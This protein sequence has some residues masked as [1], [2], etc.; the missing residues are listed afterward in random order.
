MPRR[1]TKDYVQIG[2]NTLAQG[3]TRWDFAEKL[4][5]TVPYNG[6]FAK[7]IAARPARGAELAGFAVMGLRVVSSVVEE[8]EGGTGSLTVTLE[9][10][11]PEAE[12]VTTEAIGE[13]V[14]TVEWVELEKKIETLPQCGYVSAAGAA[15]GITDLAD[16]WEKILANPDYYTDRGTTGSWTHTDYTDLKKRGVESKVVYYPKV[17]R[18]T[19]HFA[20]P[21][22]LGTY[23]GERQ[24]PP[25]PSGFARLSDFEW[26]CGPDS[27]TRTNKMYERRTEW[28]GAEEIDAILYPE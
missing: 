25:I 19:V 7:C 3:M 28:I 12:D 22:D 13:P 9:A 24:T 16:D 15:A 26:L 8:M 2:E 20:K 18:T 5:V 27:A 21:A 6:P 4:R 14:F 17:T 1:K 23:S 11:L 10:E